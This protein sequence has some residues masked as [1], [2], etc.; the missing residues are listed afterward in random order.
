MGHD[1]Y[2]AEV[3]ALPRAVGLQAVAGGAGDELVPQQMVV[4][5]LLRDLREGRGGG[6][7]GGGRDVLDWGG[8][9]FGRDRPSSQGPH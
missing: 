1:G 2:A 5:L 8:G 4:V 3:E 9:G 7:V 6:G